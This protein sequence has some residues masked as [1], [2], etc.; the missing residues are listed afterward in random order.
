MPGTPGTRTGLSDILT[1][2]AAN[3]YRLAINAI[4]DW[5]EANATL[6]SSGLFASRPTSTPASPGIAGRS[7]YATDLGLLLRDTGTGWV[8][9]GPDISG[10]Y[11]ARPTATGDLNGARFFA[12]DKAMEWQVIG[13]AWILTNAF[14]PEVT[15]LPTSPIDQ[16]ECVYIADATNGIKWHLRY[17]AASASLYKWEVIGGE[18]LIATNNTTAGGS[19]TSYFDAACS[20]VLPLAGDYLIGHGGLV[21]YE[22]GGVGN[23]SADMMLSYS[24]GATGA[25]DN[26]AARAVLPNNGNGLFA[27]E[28][29]FREKPKTIT[30]ASQTLAL[31]LRAV[32]FVN[33]GGGTV[34]VRERS[35]RARP[36]RV[37]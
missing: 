20:I 33:G 2:D 30:S 4:N 37:G 3:E 26:D 32:S 23:Y 25:N 27:W 24:I 5:L 31:K 13:G 1:G 17:R 9:V 12:T 6:T 21:S 7:Y 11:A 34:N 22:G 15:S 19:S 29:I 16:Q 8:P 28:T 10:T 14:A 35:I 36:V 18:G